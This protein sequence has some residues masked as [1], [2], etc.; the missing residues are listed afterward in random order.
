MMTTMDNRTIKACFPT[1][2]AAEQFA[3]EARL[4]FEV[5]GPK[6]VQPVNGRPY[7]VTVILPGTLSPMTLF[8]DSHLLSRVH[9]LVAKWDGTTLE[10]TP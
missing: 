1:G 10:T 3:E 5:E 4:L 7:E 2:Y 6:R 8:P 9:Q